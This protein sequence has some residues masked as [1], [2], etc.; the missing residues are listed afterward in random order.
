M[1][2]RV[3]EEME[4]LFI[5]NQKEVRSL[6]TTELNNSVED[7]NSS[8]VGVVCPQIVYMGLFPNALSLRAEI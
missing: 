2:G 6:S 4:A 5:E 1:I 8:R 3:V 7:Y